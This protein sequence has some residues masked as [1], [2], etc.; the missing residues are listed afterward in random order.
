MMEGAQGSQQAFYFLSSGC[1]PLRKG[2]GIEGLLLP[3]VMAAHVAVSGHT[4]AG[5]QNGTK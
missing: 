3:A 2:L 5:A 4:V 1:Q